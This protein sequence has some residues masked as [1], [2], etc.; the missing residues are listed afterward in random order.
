MIRKKHHL[1]MKFICIYIY[2]NKYI[3]AL[4]ETGNY[5]ILVRHPSI[6]GF[7][8]FAFSCL[9]LSIYPSTY[10]YLTVR[11]NDIHIIRILLVPLA[12]LRMQQMCT[13][14]GQLYII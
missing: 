14:K 6:T 1:Y 7:H 5:P 11:L 9:H 12:S 3:Y 10:L 4:Y 2:I 13:S 8:L